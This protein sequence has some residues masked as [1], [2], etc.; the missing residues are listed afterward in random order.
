MRGLTAGL[1]ALEPRGALA[2]GAGGAP[3]GLEL[4]LG[5]L[6][7]AAAL[8]PGVLAALTAARRRRALEVGDHVAEASLGPRGGGQDNGHHQAHQGHHCWEG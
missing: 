4:G 2:A 5:A 6:Q 7:A 8:I 1:K 3:A